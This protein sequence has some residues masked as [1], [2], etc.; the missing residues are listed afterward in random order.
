MVRVEVE[1]RLRAGQLEQRE[2]GE[3]ERG[4][5]PQV[6]GVATPQA[7][8]VA[9]DGEDREA[10]DRR[11]LRSGAPELPLDARRAASYVATP[12]PS[13][14][15][16][17][18]RVPSGRHFLLHF[19]PVVGARPRAPGGRSPPC[20]WRCGPRR[21][22]QARR[23]SPP[24]ARWCWRETPV[25]AWRRVVS[26]SPISTATSRRSSAWVPIPSSVSSTGWPRVP[27]LRRRRSTASSSRWRPGSGSSRGGAARVLAPVAAA[28]AGAA[29]AVGAARRSRPDARRLWQGHR[30]V[31]ARRG[32]GRRRRNRGAAGL[33]PRPAPRGAL[34]GVDPH[35]GRRPARGARPL[36]RR[37]RRVRR[38]RRPGARQGAGEARDRPVGRRRGAADRASPIRS[39]RA[40]SDLLQ[41]TGVAHGQPGA[42]A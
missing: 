41:R 40:A 23:C 20:S 27:K 33:L 19:L 32:R 6:P 12:L 30:A 10:A 16:P 28:E 35:R 25:T 22:V 17:S 26:G 21:V 29:L 13:G 14:R 8:G 39:A 7:E 18:G 42:A 37:H 15:V 2:R 38:A 34:P 11:I 1:G 5:R 36:A 31:D 9:D 4:D 3:Q 24:R